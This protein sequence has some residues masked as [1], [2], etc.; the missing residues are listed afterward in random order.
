MAEITI[1]RNENEGITITFHEHIDIDEMRE[2]LI[3]LLLWYGYHENSIKDI[4]PDG[5]TLVQNK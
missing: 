4:L 2:I 3:T 5:C 1:K